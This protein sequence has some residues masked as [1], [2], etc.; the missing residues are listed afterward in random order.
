[1]LFY[2]IVGIAVTLLLAVSANLNAFLGPIFPPLHA[3]SYSQV[4]SISPTASVAAS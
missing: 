1:M 4:E 2:F 3:D